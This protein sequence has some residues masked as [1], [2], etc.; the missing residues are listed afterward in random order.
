MA[1]RRIP[2]PANAD[3]DMRSLKT[4]VPIEKWS[5]VMNRTEKAGISVSK[6]LSALIDRDELDAE[7]CPTW[8]APVPSSHRTEPLPG[9]DT[10]AA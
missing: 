6:Y 10:A 9:I 2:G 8:V 4:Y 7:G 3:T 5:E 1:Q